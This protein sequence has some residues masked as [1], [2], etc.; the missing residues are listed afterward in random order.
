MCPTVPALTADATTR[1]RTVCREQFTTHPPKSDLK[2]LSKRP[3][4]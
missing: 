4:K 3:E 1:N 2:L